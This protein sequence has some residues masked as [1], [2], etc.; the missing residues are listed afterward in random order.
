MIILREETSLEFHEFTIFD[1]GAD[2][3]YQAH[4]KALVMDG[5]EG[6]GKQFARAE[7]MVQV[8]TGVVLAGVAV[9]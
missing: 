3:V 6:I 8:G 7:E 4:D 9:A 2:V 5:S 1:R